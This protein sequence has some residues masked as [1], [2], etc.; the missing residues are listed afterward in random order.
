MLERHVICCARAAHSAFSAPPRYL[1]EMSDSN[2]YSCLPS[3]EAHVTPYLR[4]KKGWPRF[5]TNRRVLATS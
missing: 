2:E 5:I 3:S 4:S 1:T